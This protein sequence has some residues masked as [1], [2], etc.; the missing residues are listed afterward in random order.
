MVHFD[1]GFVRVV[2]FGTRE[3]IVKSI[4][5]FPS[6]YVEEEMVDICRHQALNTRQDWFCIRMA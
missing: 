2:S 4:C 3:V 6:G 1:Y 5:F